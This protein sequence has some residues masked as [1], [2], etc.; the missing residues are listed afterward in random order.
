MALET[1][2]AGRNQSL[3]G[4]GFGFADRIAC[5][6][7]ILIVGFGDLLYVDIWRIR[8]LL[9]PSHSTPDL[10]SGLG[11]AVL[12]LVF[13]WGMISPRGGRWGGGEMA[14]INMP[15][16]FNP[17][18]AFGVRA[19]AATRRDCLGSARGSGARRSVGRSGLGLGRPQRCPL[20]RCHQ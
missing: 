9:D 7:G 11:F 19:Y 18:L 15:S 6:E 4:V 5:V 1:D 3:R 14:V 17:R 20:R 16:R 8:L 2:T 12:V 13:I 10:F